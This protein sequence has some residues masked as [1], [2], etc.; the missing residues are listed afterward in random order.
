MKL[1]YNITKL[2]FQ[3]IKDNNLFPP[4]TKF[5]LGYEWFRRQQLYTKN[6]YH[7]QYDINW[8][9]SANVEHTLAPVSIAYTNTSGFSPQYIAQVGTNEILRLSNLPEI[10]S[11]SY[12]RFLASTPNLNASNIFYFNAVFEAAGNL[13]GAITGAKSA[14]SKTLVGAYF[15]Q[16]VKADLD[17]R[18]SRKFSKDVYLANRIMIGIGIP[19]GNSKFLPF[20]RQF[21]IGGSSSL[22][23]FS[24]RN[25]GPGSTLTNAYQQ[26]YYP[27]VGGDYKLEMNTELRFPLFGTHF[28]S[29]VF[30]DA[31]N[32]WTR[33]SILYSPTGQFTKDFAKQIA[34]DAGIGLRYDAS[35]LI[36]R[37]DMAFP[38]AKPW[39]PEGERWVVSKIDFGNGSWRSANLVFNIGIGYPF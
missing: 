7:F 16:Y 36:I 25:L 13:A 30:I 21:I 15:A 28:K 3:G 18:Y 4:R 11:G 27:Q 22:R 19:Y 20:S 29:A 23:G 26:L 17:F 14:Y 12:Y 1:S 5:T 24:P 31:G 35:I 33:D 38:L 6:L 10:I 39:L 9:A 2:Y 37:L 8:G 34:A 32:I